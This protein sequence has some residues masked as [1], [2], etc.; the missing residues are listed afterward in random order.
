MLRLHLMCDD[1][2]ATVA[3]LT[4]KGVPTAPVADAGY[5]L[6]ATLTLPSGAEIGLYEPRHESPLT[7]LRGDSSP[8]PWRTVQATPSD[9]LRIGPVCAPR[10]TAPGRRR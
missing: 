4:A 1:I 7:H 10:R 9:R 5:G 6:A 3:E 8:V 2:E